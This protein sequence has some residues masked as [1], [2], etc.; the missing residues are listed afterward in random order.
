MGGKAILAFV[1]TLLEVVQNV[2]DP[3]LTF[4]IINS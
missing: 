4:K 2:K 1:E 3:F